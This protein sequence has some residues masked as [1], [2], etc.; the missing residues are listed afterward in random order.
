MSFTDRTP[1]HE[2]STR[3]P[4]PVLDIDL[5]REIQQLRADTR[6]L[7]GR[8]S[9]TLVKHA[10]FRV[11]LMGFK[12]G[13]RMEKHQAVGPLSIQTLAG[14]INVRAAQR[15][16]DLRLGSLLTLERGTAHDVE[17]LEDSIVLLTIGA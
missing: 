2:D 4:S 3:P 12:A 6:W 1:S 5:G 16:F 17:A 7:S 10:D 8:V 13:T 14:H 15:M 9:K 11:V